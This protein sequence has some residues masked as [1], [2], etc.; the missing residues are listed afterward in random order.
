M[1]SGGSFNPVLVLHIP[2]FGFQQINAGFNFLLN[3]PITTGIQ[4][5]LIVIITGLATASV[6]SGLGN[7]VRRL[8]ELNMILAGIFMLFILAVGP[9]LFI[10]DSFIETL[11]YYATNL[12]ALSFWTE[13]FTNT[14][15]SINGPPLFSYLGAGGF[16]GLR[17][18][19]CLLPAFRRE[20]R[21]EN[22]FWAY[23][24]CPHLL[25]L[26]G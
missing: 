13:S 26:S 11:G 7:G 16:P 12:P 1:I 5:A 9:T 2:G 8:S 24:C 14:H 20:N 23:A 10:A 21:V 15:G 6:F 4:I 19:E 25:P 22:L 18:L 17:L 3:W